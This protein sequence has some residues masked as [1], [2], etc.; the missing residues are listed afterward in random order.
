MLETPVVMALYFLAFLAGWLVGWVQTREPLLRKVKELKSA[1]MERVLLLEQMFRQ[2]KEKTQV[3]ETVTIPQLV[4]DLKWAR[5]KVQAQESD[6]DRMQKR[7]LVG[8]MDLPQ[9]HSI[10]KQRDLLQERVLY[11]EQELAKAQDQ[12][13]WRLQ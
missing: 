10:R 6:L 3:L 12:M 13:M 9:E 4:E 8:P 11:L 5:A 1:P 7:L 2:E